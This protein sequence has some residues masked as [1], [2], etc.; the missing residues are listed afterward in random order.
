MIKKHNFW[1]G[2]SF[3]I[4]SIMPLVS[5]PWFSKFLSLEEFEYLHYQFFLELLY[6]EYQT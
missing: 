6:P 5:L 2:L 1:Y 3:T 4:K